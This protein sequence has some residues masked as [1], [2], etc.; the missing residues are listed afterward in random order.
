MVPALCPRPQYAPA[1]GLCPSSISPRAI[2][3]AAISTEAPAV[4]TGLQRYS[5][6]EVK[7]RRVSAQTGHGAFIFASPGLRLFASMRAR[8]A[9]SSVV[10]AGSAV[11]TPGNGRFLTTVRLA[12]AAAEVDGTGSILTGWTR[13]EAPFSDRRGRLTG[14]SAPCGDEALTRRAALALSSPSFFAILRYRQFAPGMQ[15]AP[16]RLQRAQ[17]GNPR[18]QCDRTC[19]SPHVLHE[20]GTK[21]RGVA[22]HQ[23]DQ[24]GAITFKRTCLFIDAYPDGTF[25]YPFVQLLWQV[26]RAIKGR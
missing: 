10:I 4:F 17:D 5:T 3:P 25:V 15:A 2:P 13:V 9:R 14:L 26:L 6:A 23:H 24:P 1:A 7:L 19:G 12:G 8:Y 16:T 22:V 11:G 18:S 20:A 21:Y